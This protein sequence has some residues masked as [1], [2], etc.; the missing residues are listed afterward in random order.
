MH[1]LTSYCKDAPADW[2]WEMTS[3]NKSLVDTINGNE[4][5]DNDI[6]NDKSQNAHP[7]HDWSIWQELSPHD[8]EEATPITWTT[9]E[10]S[11]TSVTLTPDWDI[12][13]EI[14]WS[15][16][17][18]GIAGCTFSHIQ[19]HQDRKKAYQKLPLRAQLNVDADALATAYQVQYG[20][21]LPNVLMLP[22]A[23]VSLQFS[24]GTCTS[25]IPTA[26]RHAASYQP[27]A[28]YIR[29]RNQWTQAQFDRINW[30]ALKHA[31]KRKNKQRIHLT[32][33]VHDLLPTNKIVHRHNMSAQ[34]CPSCTQCTQEDRDHIMKC[35]DNQRAAWRADTLIAVGNR[36]K[37]LNT[38]PGLSIVLTQGLSNWLNGH[39][40]LSC[41]GF[42]QKYHKVI[43]HQNSIGWRQVFNGRMVVEWARLQDDYVYLQKIRG[44]DAGT[45]PTIRTTHQGK[46]ARNGTQW[47]GD[48]I[49]TLWDQWHIVWTMRNTVIHGHDQDTRAR[50]IRKND[51]QRLQSIY[52][53][54][55]MMEPSAQELLFPSVEEH[56]QQ[57]G[58]TAIHNWLSIH[59]TTFI[60]SVKQA[61]KRAIQ[62]VRSLKTYFPLR[63]PHSDPSTATPSRTTQPSSSITHPTSRRPRSTILSYFATGRPP[64]ITHRHRQHRTVDSIT[65]ESNMSPA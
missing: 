1:H 6:T 7:F 63:R 28:S 32:K 46:R 34:K 27:L 24:Y 52:D 55:H 44:T 10:H 36:C 57:R 49:V 22:H 20:Q 16:T 62:G 35:N 13:N 23:A 25:N 64:D 18:A 26:I 59:E 54:K 39:E 51:L 56:Q 12:L 30:T 65:T 37:Q 48:I 2:K 42:P 11:R 9:S 19:G 41:S 15:M 5:E 58:P 45:P 47:T 61:T 40:E 8:I 60:Q 21:A 33:L 29:S 3:D 14:R 4:E 31:I 17:Q 50:Q 38:D 43:H 53:Q